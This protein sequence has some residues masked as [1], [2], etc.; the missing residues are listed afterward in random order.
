MIIRKIVFV[1]HVIQ[2]IYKVSVFYLYNKNQLIFSIHDTLTKENFMNYNLTK[3]KRTR[4]PFCGKKYI[5]LI[6][7]LSMISVLLLGCNAKQNTN[8]KNTTQKESSTEGKKES[9]STTT[10]RKDTK[11]YTLKSISYQDNDI[12]LHYPS[13]TGMKDLDKQKELN[14]MIKKEFLSFTKPSTYGYDFDNTQD[15]DSTETISYDVKYSISYQS[16]HLL[17]LSVISFV[18]DSLAPHPNTYQYGLTYDLTKI[19]KCTLTDFVDVN[20]DFANQIL[21]SDTYEGVDSSEVSSYI[22]EQGASSAITTLLLNTQTSFVL[23]KDH[24]GVILYVPHAI[25]DS[26]IVDVPYT[27]SNQ[28]DYIPQTYLIKENETLVYGFQLKD[29]NKVAIIAQD[30]NHKYTLYRF[31]TKDHIELSY[32]NT[33]NS[34]SYDDFSYANDKQ[35]VTFTNENYQYTISETL[36]QVSIQVTNLTTNHTT[37]LQGDLNSSVGYLFDPKESY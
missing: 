14:Q 35:A 32:P 16:D 22:K 1:V 19:K 6:L 31:G 11:P 21:Q 18:N 26:V 15:V 17:S 7:S 13:I 30:Q 5:V 12:T 10:E 23:G 9:S 3:N 2:R 33:L 4:K 34:S 25:G 20:M 28:T 8:T 27:I 29:S 37:T 24:I 36:D